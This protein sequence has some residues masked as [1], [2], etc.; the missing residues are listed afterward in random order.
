M[1]TRVFP[2][3]FEEYVGKIISLLANKSTFGIYDIDDISQ[4]IYIL[5]LD[6]LDRYDGKRNLYNFLFTHTKNRLKNLKRN[7]YFRGECPC[8]LCDFK[9]EG[10]T[11]HKNKKHCELYKNWYANNSRKSNIAQPIGFT[12]NTDIADNNDSGQEEVDRRDFLELVE[13]EIPL[14]LRETYLKMKSGVVVQN[15]DREKVLEFLK[16]YTD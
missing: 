11:G 8:K 6:A 5:C 3:N 16:K 14:Y 7:K 12:E 9:P 4:E 13:R 15:R 10:E 2:E 1:L